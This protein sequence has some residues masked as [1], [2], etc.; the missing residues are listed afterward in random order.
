MR[1]K[2][3]NFDFLRDCQDYVH[4]I[5]GEFSS[6]QVLGLSTTDNRQHTTDK[7]K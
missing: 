5:T 6:P 3:D 7:T 2:F 1:S 4:Q